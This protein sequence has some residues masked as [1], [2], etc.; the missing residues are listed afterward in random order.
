MKFITGC[1]LTGSGVGSGILF[2]GFLNALS[3]SPD[4]EEI[5]FGY[6]ILIIIII[7]LAKV[8]LTKKSLF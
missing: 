1:S 7:R 6:L 2:K 3:N 8:F 4:L 5:L